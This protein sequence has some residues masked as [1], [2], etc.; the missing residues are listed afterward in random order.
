VKDYGEISDVL[1][2][3]CWKL[4]YN[5]FFDI[6]QVKK[7]WLFFFSDYYISSRKDAVMSPEPKKILEVL[8]INGRGK[9]NF[10]HFTE[11]GDAMVWEAGFVKDEAVREAIRYLNENQYII[12]FNAGLGLTKKGKEADLT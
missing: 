10:V 7:A 9:D 5:R 4:R 6:S 8:K 2:E 1:R 11:F 12:E 3:C